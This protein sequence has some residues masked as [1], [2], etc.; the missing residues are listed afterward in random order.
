MCTRGSALCLT[1]GEEIAYRQKWFR[2]HLDLHVPRMVP[3]CAMVV[4]LFDLA[5]VMH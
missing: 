5:Q 2:E 4:D 1:K 3:I